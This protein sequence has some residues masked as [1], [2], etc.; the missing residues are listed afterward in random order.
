MDA[1]EQFLRLFKSDLH[2][3]IED[4]YGEKI[5]VRS[6]KR[7]KVVVRQCLAYYLDSE[8]E[9]YRKKAK[10]FK[11]ELLAQGYKYKDV[12]AT[13]MEK[14][15]YPR[16]WSLN[17]IAYLLRSEINGFKCNHTDIL[18]AKKVINNLNNGHYED[19]S[20]TLSEITQLV[21]TALSAESRKMNKTRK[22]FNY[23]ENHL[24]LS[25]ELTTT[26]EAIKTFIYKNI[27]LL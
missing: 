8:A 9:V 25:E 4:Y 14:D 2:R 18:H 6:R 23:V 3:H 13:A 5:F 21:G 24:I 26:F 12:T 19:V 15:F 27:E 20:K 16:A 10:E 22:L 11:D 1:K 7:R 17:D